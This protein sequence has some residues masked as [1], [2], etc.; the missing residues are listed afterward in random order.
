MFVLDLVNTG[1]EL[2]VA[3]VTRSP[4]EKNIK[5]CILTHNNIY[6][7]GKKKR[8]YTIIIISQNV[9]LPIKPPKQTSSPNTLPLFKSSRPPKQCRHDTREAQDDTYMNPGIGYIK[10]HRPQDTD[11]SLQLRKPTKT[12]D[13]CYGLI[14]RPWKESSTTKKTIQSVFYWYQF[15][16]T[17]S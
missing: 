16:N 12:F 14:A 10:K 8:I 15:I 9:I 5:R 2:L 17:Y 4:E 13:S 11:Y 3:L 7:D 6:T 1:K